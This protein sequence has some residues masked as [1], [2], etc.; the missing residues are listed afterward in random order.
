MTAPPRMARDITA[1]LKCLTI[2]HPIVFGKKVMI[3]TTT[4]PGAVF[5]NLEIA[6]KLTN[7]TRTHLEKTILV[8]LRFLLT[9]D[10]HTL[11]E[12]D[13]LA[14][15]R[16][17]VSDRVIDDN[18]KTVSNISALNH[19]SIYAIHRLTGAKEGDMLPRDRL[20][21]ALMNE[22]SKVVGW[23]YE[24]ITEDAGK[25]K[26]WIPLITER[27]ENLKNVIVTENTV[28]AINLWTTKLGVYNP[29]QAMCVLSLLT[30]PLPDFTLTFIPPLPSPVTVQQPGV[31]CPAH[32]SYYRYPADTLPEGALKKWSD[33]FDKYRIGLDIY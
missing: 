29:R 10:K 9:G 11:I 7:L 32:L 23:L 33:T 19:N 21:L 22:I 2:R 27:T 15:L 5:P 20:P 12:D 13:A 8:L 6:G 25:G 26:V 4:G 18:L 30:H 1:F 14:A 31:L 3:K 24:R 17:I 16:G 28:W